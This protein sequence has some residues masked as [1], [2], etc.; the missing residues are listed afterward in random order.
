MYSY[1]ALDLCRLCSI[2]IILKD[3][4]TDL[5]NISKYKG[6]LSNTIR[7]KLKSSHFCI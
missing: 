2:I 3:K 6:S 1:F 5:G 4:R 7:M